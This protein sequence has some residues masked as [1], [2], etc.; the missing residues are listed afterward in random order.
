MRAHGRELAGLARLLVADPGSAEDLVQAALVRV[1]RAWPKVEAATDRR[2]YVRRVLVNLAVSE[3][4]RRWRAEVPSHR[5]PETE[6]SEGHQQADDRDELVRLLRLLPARQRAA[7]ALRYFC[8][9]DDTAVAAA[10][11]CSVAT[12]RSQISRALARLRVVSSAREDDR[13]RRGGHMRTYTE[14]DLRAALSTE[15]ARAVPPSPGPLLAHEDV[16]VPR[17]ARAAP[18]WPLRW[19]LSSPSLSRSRS[20]SEAATMHRPRCGC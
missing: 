5:L 1:W 7:V 13:H 9:L 18:S 2:A 8:D 16:T 17:R 4:R 20:L 3:R 6:S 19:P 11:G 10:L 15:A 12:V 14:D